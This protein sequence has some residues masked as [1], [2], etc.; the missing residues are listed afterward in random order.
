MPAAQADDRRDASTYNSQVQSATDYVV[1]CLRPIAHTFEQAIQR[2]LIL[3]KDTYF[4]EFKLAA[5]LRGDPESQAK[6]LTELIKVRVMR[7]SEARLILNM[8][9]DADLDRL[10]EQDFR[11][12]APNSGGSQPSA[13]AESGG[14]TRALLRGMLAIH[15]HATRCVRRER[16]AVEKLARKH[17]SDVA[18]WQAAL[19]DFYGDHARFVAETM[20]LE[21]RLARAYAAQHGTEF[22]A[23]GVV[24]I[25]GAAGDEWERFE[26]DELAALAVDGERLAA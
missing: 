25:D 14:R 15:D 19:R 5:L 13:S 23:K 17:A 8:N 21:P 18:G 24:L 4:S 11:P 22:E 9:P 26:A 2:D 10:S 20:R 7:P 3:A 1:T 6:F 12:G 16:I